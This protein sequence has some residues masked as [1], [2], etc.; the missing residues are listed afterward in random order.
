MGPVASCWY[1]PAMKTTADNRVRE[2]TLSRYVWT[3]AK[4]EQAT[5]GGLLGPD[6]HVELIG[7]EIVAKMTQNS[8]HST[9]VL[10]AEAALRAAF[11]AG[12]V[13]RSQ[14]PLSIGD[15]SQPEPDIAVVSGSIRDFARN[16]PT[17]ESAVLVVEVSDTSLAADRSVKG[18]LYALAGIQEFWIINLNDRVV[19]VRRLPAASDASAFGYAY[20]GIQVFGED[21]TFAPGGAPTHPIAVTD[22]L[23]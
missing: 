2:A 23:P 17:A 14:M 6:D 7:G 11:S 18:S 12:F 19:E 9:A 21:A 22:L 10:L 1:N 16:H 13:V 20:A 8:P 4:Y 15:N 5:A 3:R